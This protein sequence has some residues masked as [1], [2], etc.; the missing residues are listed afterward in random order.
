M[1]VEPSLTGNQEVSEYYFMSLDGGQQWTLVGDRTL[2]PG[3]ARNQTV[4]SFILNICKPPPKR[5]V[6][7]K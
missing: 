7:I 5:C 2:S 6:I 3:D 4:G 1:A